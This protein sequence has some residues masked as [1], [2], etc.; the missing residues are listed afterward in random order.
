MVCRVGPRVMKMDAHQKPSNGL[1]VC[2]GGDRVSVWFCAQV[3]LAE[4]CDGQAHS[5]LNL[6][7]RG[8]ALR[9]LGWVILVV[10]DHGHHGVVPPCSCWVLKWFFSTRTRMAF[11]DGINKRQYGSMIHEYK[12]LGSCQWKEIQHRH[13]RSLL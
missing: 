1:C 8:R 13:S 5:S 4:F 11:V 10:L 6:G 3:N 12:S 7:L 2:R 9:V